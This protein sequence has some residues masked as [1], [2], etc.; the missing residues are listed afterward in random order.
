MLTYTVYAI[1]GCIVIYKYTCNY[2]FISNRLYVLIILLFLHDTF[3][4]IRRINSNFTF[5]MLIIRFS[6]RV[7]IFCQEN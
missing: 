5:Y 7:Q 6:E 1:Y 2:I 4:L 3:S